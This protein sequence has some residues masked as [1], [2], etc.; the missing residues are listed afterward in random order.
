MQYPKKIQA[1]ALQ[2][3][4]CLGAVVAVLLSTFVLLHHTHHIFDQKTAKVIEIVKK[5]DRGLRY[6]MTQ[7]IPLN[8]PVSMPLG[9]EDGIALTVAKS[10]WGV[11]ET[12]TT[13]STFQKN[14]F[15]KTALVGGKL[16]ED[17]PALYLKDNNRPLVIAGTSKITG[18]AY[19][20]Q[21]G[22]RQGSISGHFHAFESPI[23]GTI[24]RSTPTLPSL[25]TGLTSHLQQLWNASGKTPGKEVIRFSERLEL[26]RSFTDSTQ[27]IYGESLRLSGVALKGNIVVRA[28][29]QI[30]IDADSTVEDV[31]LIAPK[32]SIKKGFTGSLQ[33]MASREITVEEQVELTYPSALVVDRGK[34]PNR[35]NRSTPN[36]TIGK[37]ATVKGIVAYFDPST[38]YAF[39]PHIAIA[40]NASIYGEVYCEKNLELKGNIVGKVTT[41]S[42]IALEN[43]SVYQNHL[44]NGTINSN[45][46]PLQY[47]GL[48]LNGEKTVAQWLY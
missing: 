35:K 29:T 2:F 44:F 43:G 18:N 25:A 46:L 48:I 14:Q 5:A 42:F 38:A 16:Q 28:T 19:L 45:P 15:T 13:V 22:I 11:F 12:Y 6:A 36:I 17:F 31:V 24:R 47:A 8:E 30:V 1:G 27:Y 41:D 7:D 21:Q 39:F 33:A 4:L 23:Y 32:I 34:T 40:K 20:P 26:A 3:V 10:Y 37:D 9:D